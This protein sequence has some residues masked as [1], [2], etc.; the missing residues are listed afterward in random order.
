MRVFWSWMVLLVVLVGCKHY[1]LPRG[2]PDIDEMSDIL[3]EIQIAESTISQLPNQISVSRSNSPGYFKFIL[4]KYGYTALEFD[5]IRKWYAYHPELYLKVYDKMLV[6]LSKEEAGLRSKSDKEKE[7]E[8]KEAERL[9]EERKLKNLWRDSTF[10][11]VAP[12]DT[13]DKQ[14]PFLIGVDTLELKGV[15]QLSA[16]YKFMKQDVSEQPKVIL[17]ALYH[18]L[19]KDSVFQQI[20]HSFNE[21]AVNLSL[22]LRDSIS[23]QTIEG[24]LL[25]QDSTI[26]ADVQIRNIYLENKVDSLKEK[27]KEEETN[28]LKYK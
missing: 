5:S 25:Y 20:P 14:L 23:P 4:D 26:Q 1:N 2:F 13:F 17:S 16:L 3:V 19:I 21:K 28:F 27:S 10:L 6:K 22:V 9:A 12:T 18:D 15:L 8:K 24:Y 7:L 11:S